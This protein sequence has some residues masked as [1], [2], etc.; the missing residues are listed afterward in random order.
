MKIGDFE[1]YRV[2]PSTKVSL[3][4]HDPG[5]RRAFRGDKDAALEAAL[6]LSQKLGELQ[7]LL[8]AGHEHKVLVVLQGMDT[9]G[10][11]GV[12][13]H[14]FEGINPQGVKV[15]AF[16]APTPEE[17]G[18][19]FLWRIHKCVPGKG[20]IAIFNR[21]HYED[22]LVVRV[23]NLV[24][25]EVWKPRYDSINGFE[26]TLHQEG[27][28]ILKFFLHISKDE[29]RKRLQA[30]LDDPTK[31]WKFNPADLPERRLWTDY[32]KAYEEVLSRTSTPYAPW[33]VVPANKKWY[34]NLAV[35][36]LLVE[37]ME[38]LHMKFPKADFNPA[39]I[40]ID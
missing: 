4:E 5:D 31:R 15:H 26:K 14:V 16:K 32:Q 13:R 22:V 7:E 24:P 3:G 29:Q 40:V 18:H 28:V 37:A 38:G 21:S 25:Q 36:T 17:L 30:R 39:K 10:K 8:Y 2:R 6:K 34:R 9:S 33:F 20:E 35:A 1:R 27:V 12:V 19:D 11:D 23:H